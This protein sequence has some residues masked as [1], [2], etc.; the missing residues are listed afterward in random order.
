MDKIEVVPYKIW[1]VKE[2]LKYGMN[3]ER[4]ELD[5]KSYEDKIDFSQPGMS[6]T[7]LANDNPVCSGG[8]MP[9]WTGVAEGWVI[10]SRRIF[11]FTLSAAKEIKKRT[12][13]ICVNNKIWRLQTAVR[14]DFKTGLRFAKWLGLEKEG[15]MKKYGPDGADYYKM[16]KIYEYNR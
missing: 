2:I 16:A 10:S 13:Y 14:A 3:D 8:V 1:H 5:A 15:L 11:D 9:L 12:D 7:L 4:V 6:F